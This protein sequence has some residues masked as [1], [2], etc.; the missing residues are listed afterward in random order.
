MFEKLQSLLL[1]SCIATCLI[2]GPVALP[3]QPPTYA[4]E[5]VAVNGY[6]VVAYFTEGEPVEGSATYATTLD[7]V[8]WRF[9]TKEHL[10]LFKANPGRYL[11][12]FGGWCAYGVSNNYKAPTKPDAW[13]IVDDK[14]YLNY[15][16]NVRK[17]WLSERNARI[18]A[19]EE[20]WTTLKSK[21]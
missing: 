14:L 1:S 4:V 19:A 8:E 7:G 11:P 12:Q 3:G 20:N 16:K 5:G 21:E 2:L 18:R 6:D 9:A 15:N 10:D 13:T 17:T